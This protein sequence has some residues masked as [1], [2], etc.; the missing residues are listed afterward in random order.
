MRDVHQFL[1]EL[2][3]VRP[4]GALPHRVTYHDACHLA[5]AQQVR[6]APRNLLSSIPELQLVEL[7]ES[8][9]CCGAA[10]TY[11]LTQ[12][13]M[14]GRLGRRKV[15]HIIDTGAEILASAN[16]GCT[17]QIASQA[18]QR[19]HHLRVL[20]PMELLDLSYRQQPLSD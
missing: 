3:L 19:G 4:P 20:H 7:A 2:G 8:E 16:A 5:H 9:L 13:E 15:D 6:E 10:G 11:N 14:A 17:L 12:P 18:R 1:D